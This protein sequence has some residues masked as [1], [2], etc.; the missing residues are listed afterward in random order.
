MIDDRTAHLN[1]PLPNAANALIDDVER[2][3]TTLTEIDAQLS[4]QPVLFPAI[5]SADV[6]I[7]VDH[8]ALSVGPLTINYGATVIVQPGSTW[9]II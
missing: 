6:M 8:H 5:L 4:I 1:L 3:R 9:A 7:P 2:I